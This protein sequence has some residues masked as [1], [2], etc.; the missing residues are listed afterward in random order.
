M[1]HHAKLT[2]FDLPY[3][4]RSMIYKLVLEDGLDRFTT[5]D[6]TI[7]G[8][9]SDL[10]SLAQQLANAYRIMAR[11][12]ANL[13]KLAVLSRTFEE[14]A[15]EQFFRSTQIYIRHEPST[16]PE[17]QQAVELLINEPLFRKHTVNVRWGVMIDKDENT[18]YPYSQDYF[19]RWRYDNGPTVPRVPWP[20][21]VPRCLV[22]MD[23]LD[24]IHLDVDHGRDWVD[25]CGN[26]KWLYQ[27]YLRVK[28]LRLALNFRGATR[29]VN[30][31]WKSRYI[32]NGRPRELLERNIL[33][34]L[35]TLPEVRLLLMTHK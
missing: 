28:K 31:A 34:H 18:L 30:K 14:E 25:L 5:D 22:R 10:A 6:E 19:S 3:D 32:R 1:D 23:K 27:V 4:I 29:A 17:Y 2:F 12:L 24:S 26:P 35:L 13:K 20:E 8:D 7:Q 16:F 9:T 15:C 11:Q 21:E 33:N